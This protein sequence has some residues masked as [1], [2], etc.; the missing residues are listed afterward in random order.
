MYGRELKLRRKLVFMMKA[1]VHSS[2]SSTYSKHWMR[3][4]VIKQLH[5]V[6]NK[7]SKQLYKQ[8]YSQSKI[9]QK[10]THKSS[11][12]AVHVMI[13]DMIINNGGRDI[14]ILFAVTTNQIDT[15][16]T[17]PMAAV[18]LSGSSPESPLSRRGS[19]PLACRAHHRHYLQRRLTSLSRL[20]PWGCLRSPP[21]GLLW[22]PPKTASSLSNCQYQIHSKTILGPMQ[23]PYPQLLSTK[24]GNQD[25]IVT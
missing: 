12:P 2:H 21:M 17:S 16:H 19:T 9:S 11:T 3:L 25:I 1:Y 7:P 10:N 13:I 4:I 5:T 22:R 6:L 23:C 15:I 8:Q 18:I 24:V 20:Q 14:A